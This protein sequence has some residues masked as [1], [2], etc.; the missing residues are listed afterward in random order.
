[1]LWEWLVMPQGL[2][3]APAT[4]NRMVSHVLR[5]LRAFAPSYFDD[6]FVHSRAE[7]GLSAVDVHLRHLRKVFEKMR[8]NKLYAN[9]KKCVFCAPEILVLGCYV[10][11]SGVRADPEKISSICSWP[12]PK[13]QTELRQWLGLANYLH[14]YTKDYAGLI[15][16]MSSLLKKDVAWN[17]RPEHQDAFDAVK[18][19]LASAPVL[20]Q[21]DTSRPF[22]VV[23][24][25]SDFAIGCA[26]MQFDAEGR[27]RVVSYQ[28]RQMKPAEKNYPVHDKELL[29]MRYALIKFRV[30]L[31]GEQTF[32]VYTDHASLRTAMKSPHLS[33]RMARWLSFFAEY[34]FVLHYKPGKNKILADALSRRPDYDPRRLTHHQDIPDDDDDDDDCATCVTLGINATVSSPVLPLRQQ[35]ADAYEEDAFY[36]AIIR[37]LRNPTADT[38][39]KLTRPTRDA[40]TRYDLDG[41]LLTY[42]ID[43]FDTPRVVIPADDDLR[44]HLVH[45]YHDAPAGGHLGREKTFAAL[46]RDFFWPRM[47]KWIRK[48]VRSCEICQ[49]VKPAASKQAPLRPLPIATSAW[50]SVSM[51]F[52]FGLPR[53]AEG[54]TGVLVFV[55]RF[56][57]MVHLAPVAAEVTADESA[58]LFLDLVFRHHGLP[59]SIVSDRDPRFTSA[60]WTRLFALLGTRL[61]MSTAAHP[62]TD[63]QTERVNRVLEDVLRSYATSFASWSSFLPMAEFA[64]NNSTHASTGL[65]PFFVNNARHPRV[66]ALLAVRS[67]NAA[68]VSTLG[69]GG[70]APTSKSAQDLSEPPVPQPAKP[71]T[72]EATVEGHALHGVA[73][74]DVFAVDVAS[75]AT[76]AVANF[77]PAAT[78]TPIDSAAVSEFLLHRQ[79]VTRFVRDALQVAVDRQKA[80]AN[81]RGRKNM[82]SFRR[83]E[84]V[85]LSTEGIQGT[86]VTNLG[87][88]KLA[89]RFIGPFKILKVIGDA[90]TLDVPTAMRLHPTFYVGRLKPYVPATI[91]A[92]EAERPRPARNPNRPAVDADAESSRA[93]APHARASPS[94]TRAPPSDEATSA[95]CAAP[96]L[97]ESQ[98]SPQ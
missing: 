32:V 82:S 69:G 10:S 11:M 1:M 23:C 58:E 31:L 87:A 92:P 48:W 22:H 85:F 16:P 19:S 33:Q 20:M 37:Y 79:A 94:V 61:L 74:E 13:N 47:Y 26:L 83:G 66:P 68:A 76:S 25:A 21:P 70:V 46:S 5:P 6:I 77:A 75:P 64:L 55:D 72:R 36:A 73:Y 3:N 42:A 9:L 43:T 98:Q 89:P 88:N 50:R 34:N 62:E 59:E 40:I 60:F 51:D 67:S 45:E 93:L 8:E 27:K 54:R 95:S 81:R 29:A 97:I 49:R 35:I 41:D 71:N 18:K 15:Q 63:G 52:I 17:W 12:T 91:P 65:T 90:Y 7:D 30:Y 38:L 96:A 86:A 39:A 28:S 57:K 53:D 44:A 4:F 24:D 56:S 80:N 84:R 78:P 2:K 14:K